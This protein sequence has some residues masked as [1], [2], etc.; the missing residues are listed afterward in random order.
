MSLR[1]IVIGVFTSTLVLC[2]HQETEAQGLVEYGKLLGGLKKPKMS[3]SG[4]K[5]LG[6][7]TGSQG[8]G[9][10]PIPPLPNVLSVEGK[11]VYLYTRQDKHSETITK[12]EHGEEL[13]PLGEALG[14]GEA[15]YMVKTQ[16]G[17]VGWIQ[18]SRVKGHARGS[19]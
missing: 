17:A 13:T 8:S 16:K 15:W 12:L 18:S 14:S 19:R 11:E 9:Q 1:W 2:V 5:Y 3:R 7:G 6:S 10:L 4:T